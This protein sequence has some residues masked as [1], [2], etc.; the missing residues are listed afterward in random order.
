MGADGSDPDL[1]QSGAAQHAGFSNVVGE[2]L[3]V[4]SA[5]KEYCELR[6]S[7]GTLFSVHKVKILEQSSVL[8]CAF[9]CC[10]L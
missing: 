3:G 2:R 8:R 5:S 1:P 9:S 6:C 4:M 10:T 7:D